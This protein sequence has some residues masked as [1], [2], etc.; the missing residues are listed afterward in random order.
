MK[1]EHAG[2]TVY[3]RETGHDKPMTVSFAR[4]WYGEDWDEILSQCK[5]DARDVV[6]VVH[7]EGGP[8]EVIRRG[9]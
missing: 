5:P 2:Y 3:D 7:T 1:K 4:F 9:M 6:S 8:L